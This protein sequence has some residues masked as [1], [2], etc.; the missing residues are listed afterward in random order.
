[1]KETQQAKVL[2]LLREAGTIGVNSY[3]FTFGESIKQI[4]TRVFE[5][6]EQGYN[7]ASISKSNRSV[8]YILIEQGVS[9]LPHKARPLIPAPTN[10]WEETLIPVKKTIMFLGRERVITSWEK[11]ENLKPVQEALGV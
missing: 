9:C 7:I 2:R 11:P 5:L 4:A 1:M 8:Q 3:A 10:P 6:K